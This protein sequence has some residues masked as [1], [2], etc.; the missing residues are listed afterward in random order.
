M[1]FYLETHC[2]V[3]EIYSFKVVIL[4]SELSQQEMECLKS[5]FLL[6]FGMRIAWKKVFLKIM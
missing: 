4:S 5:F 2:N 3:K 6:W 1:T